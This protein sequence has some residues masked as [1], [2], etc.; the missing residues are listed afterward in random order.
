MF[1][2][3]GEKRVI[4]PQFLACNG[5]GPSYCNLVRWAFLSRL[6]WCPFVCSTSDDLGQGPVSHKLHCALCCGGERFESN[7]VIIE[8][9][10]KYE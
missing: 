3:L 10:R 1:S 7:L 2:V 8:L 4:R 5:P 6:G 9:A